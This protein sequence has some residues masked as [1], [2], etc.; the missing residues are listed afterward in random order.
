MRKS[1]IGTGDKVEIS[2]QNREKHPGR[3]KLIVDND[4]PKRK[5]LKS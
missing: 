4:I 2:R 3:K 1:I 5:L